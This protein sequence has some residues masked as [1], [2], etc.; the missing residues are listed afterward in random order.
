MSL[1]LRILGLVILIASIIGAV[2]MYGALDL[3]ALTQGNQ[4]L[5]ALLRSETV[6]TRVEMMRFWSSIY[7]VLMGLGIGSLCFAASELLGR[8]HHTA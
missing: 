4:M 3:G 2:K 7:M 8:R 6:E 5:T 1:Y